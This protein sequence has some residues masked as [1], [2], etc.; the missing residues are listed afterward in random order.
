M[1]IRL[2][3]FTSLLMFAVVGCG[4]SS[5]EAVGQPLNLPVSNSKEVQTAEP[6]LDLPEN[7]IKLVSTPEVADMSSTPPSKDQLVNLA[8]QDLAVR[9]K[10]DSAQI[11]LLKTLEIKSPNISAGC[12]L[13]AGQ[14]LTQGS[15][16]YGYRI[17]LEADGEEYIYHA[18][19]NETIIFCPKMTP[20]AN[21][22]F[23]M[24]PDGSSQDPQNQ[25]P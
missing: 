18:G 13:G 6:A 4:D 23:F 15:Q 8:K 10:I 16:V 7:P 12:K 3:L 14:I 5:Q 2:I 25:S 22:P 11:T 24:T 1:N 17:W 9:L 21:N 20:G 19:I